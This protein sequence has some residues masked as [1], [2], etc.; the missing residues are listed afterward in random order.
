MEEAAEVV[1]GGGNVGLD[2]GIVEFECRGV[3]VGGTEVWVGTE[4]GPVVADDAVVGGPVVGGDE[5]GGAVSELGADVVGGDVGLEVVSLGGAVDSDG[6]G[7]AGG[8]EVGGADAP[9]GVNANC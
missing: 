1:V 3:P 2:A 5:D 8:V 9:V 4:A 7:V 6:P